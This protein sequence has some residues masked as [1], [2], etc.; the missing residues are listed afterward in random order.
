MWISAH[1]ERQSLCP[2]RIYSGYILLLNIPCLAEQVYA[3][4]ASALQIAILRLFVRCECLLPN[5][6]VGTVSRE[7]VLSALKC[8][9]AAE[10][11]IGYLRTHAHPKLAARM[12]VV[13]EAR[14]SSSPPLRLPTIPPA[15]ESEGCDH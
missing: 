5:L 2:V 13:P 8:G 6:F 3:Y 11:I 12:P 4:A 15:P 14:F 7:S 9:L 10:D 1:L